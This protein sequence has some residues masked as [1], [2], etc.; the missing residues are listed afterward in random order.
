ML[1]THLDKSYHI[2]CI[3]GVDAVF[4]CNDLDTVLKG[5]NTYVTIPMFPEVGYSE[6]M[7]SPNG[8]YYYKVNI[9]NGYILTIY[10]VVNDTKLAEV[11][12]QNIE[13]GGW[14]ADNSG[15]YFQIYYHPFGNPYIISHREAIKKL[16]VY[17]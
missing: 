7:Y 5:Y 13:P 16:K 8:A 4:N 1:S 10:D 15:V 2:Y 14:A 12:G 9:R 3:D 6:K 17:Q 11:K